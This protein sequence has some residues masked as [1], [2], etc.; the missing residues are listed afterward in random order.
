M[1]MKG[2][3]EDVMMNIVWIIIA[4]VVV[5]SLFL[6]GQFIF[7]M[8]QPQN[9]DT[10]N[11]GISF[12]GKVGKVC[13]DAAAAAGCKKCDMQ[14]VIGLCQQT[15]YVDIVDKFGKVFADGVNVCAIPA[16]SSTVKFK[17]KYGDNQEMNKTEST[18]P[19]VEVC[20][21][22]N[23]TDSGQLKEVSAEAGTGPLD[24]F[25]VDFT[26]VNPQVS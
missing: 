13:Y 9:I 2:V 15:Q 12:D 5:S 20:H 26:V 21:K 17:V 1:T 11:T 14:Q 22:F 10:S 23:L 16:E 25:K 3:T 19:H 7:S 8:L 18:R 6:V 24:R 4:A